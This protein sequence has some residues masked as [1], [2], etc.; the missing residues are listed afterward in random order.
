MNSLKGKTSV[1]LH[2]DTVNEMSPS[3][4][5]PQSSGNPEE[6]EAEGVGETGQIEDTRTKCSKANE[7]AHMNSQGWGAAVTGPTWV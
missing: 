6:Q 3:N 4:L 1:G 2:T 7:S 5:S